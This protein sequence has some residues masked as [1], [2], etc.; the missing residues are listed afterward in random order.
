[1]STVETI[2]EDADWYKALTLIERADTF[3]GGLESQQSDIELGTHRLQRWQEQRPFSEGGKFAEKL[4]VAGL[5]A[6]SFTRLLGAPIENVKHYAVEQPGWLQRMR[7]AYTN[8]DA[9]QYLLF[10][11]VPADQA[12]V[13]LLTWIEP[14]LQ[15]GVKQVRTGM[16]QLQERYQQVPFD[17]SSSEQLIFSQLPK[18][19][20]SMVSRTLVLELNVARLQNRLAGDSS[21]ERYQD[22]IRLLQQPEFALQL[23]LEYPVL[24][25]SVMNSIDLWVAYSLEFLQ[26]LCEDRPLLEENFA[27]DGLGLLTELSGGQGDSHNFG[28]SVMI[29]DFSSGAKVVYKPRPLAVD[30]HF[31]ELLTWLNEKGFRP[32]FRILTVLDC[33]QHGWLEFVPAESCTIRA[34]MK[35]FYQRQGGYLALLYALEAVDFHYEN[36]I[37]SGEHPVLVDLESLFH[38]H[39]EALEQNRPGLSNRSGDQMT[40]SVLRVGLLPQ[41]AWRKEDQPGVDFSGFGAKSGQLTPIKVLNW[42][43]ESSDEMRFTRKRVPMPGGQNRPMLN[44]QDIDVLDYVEAIRQGFHD[45]YHLLLRERETLLVA[46]GPIARFAADDVRVIVRPTMV[47]ALLLQESYHPDFLRDAVERDR[48]FDRLWV[49]AETRP[50]LKWLI[51]HEYNDFQRGDIPM[52]TTKPNSRS[53]WNC[54]GAEIPELLDDSSL[55]HV[56]AHIKQLSESDLERQSWF[57]SASLTTL[58]MGTGQA[59]WP[60]Y[61]F[62]PAQAATGRDE[63]L[64]KA[65]AI[66]DRIATLAMQPDNG[67]DPIWLGVTLFDEQDWALLPLSIDLYNG[68]PGIAIFLAQLGALA[69][70]EKYTLLARRIARTV[71]RQ[72]RQAQS[73]IESVGGY[74]GW[75]SLI[76]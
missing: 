41:R 13:L 67:E 23:L 3:N 18:R 32:Q 50:Y 55:N 22:F 65:R 75:G 62:V 4:Q 76:Y 57:I 73:V 24:A 7:K 49:A 9:S 10:A 74:N 6:A 52:F 27:P 15:Q 20:L 33:G 21:G 59:H 45:L 26:H 28:R 68:V 8:F 48:H 19:L 42:E 44:G 64:D 61:P 35:R 58:A 37:S 34:Q 2:F 39:L 29:A 70:E 17:L 5:D 69:Q 16:Q 12:H 25:R 40:Y 71:I 46:D 63:Y 1:M 31:Q 43:S 14:L 30:V 47:Y 51:P 72:S 56:R 11:E 53:L 60:S 36:L 54:T 38:P 66:G